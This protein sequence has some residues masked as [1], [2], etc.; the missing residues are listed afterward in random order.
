MPNEAEVTSS[1]PPPPSSVDMSKKKKI[2]KEWNTNI[3]TGE[4][5]K[6]RPWC[7]YDPFPFQRFMR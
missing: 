2:E 3:H 1:N 7:E 6:I 4:I 5:N